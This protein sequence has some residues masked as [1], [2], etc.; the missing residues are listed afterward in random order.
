MFV[1]NTASKSTKTTRRGVGQLLRG[2]VHATLDRL[3][4]PE[5][6]APPEYYR[7]PWF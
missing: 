2:W 3:T 4:M 1:D 5:R 6:D 7:F